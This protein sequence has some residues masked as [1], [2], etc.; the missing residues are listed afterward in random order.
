MFSSFVIVFV[1]LLHRVFAVA[2]VDDEDD[3]D[4]DDGD[5]VDAPL[6]QV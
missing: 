2:V 3:D 4:S 6:Q 1:F 5:N